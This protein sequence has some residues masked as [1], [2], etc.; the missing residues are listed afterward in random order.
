MQKKNIDKSEVKLN[1]EFDLSYFIMLGISH[2]L[3]TIL[4]EVV[5]EEWMASII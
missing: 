1:S 4:E 3:L 2:V 5:F